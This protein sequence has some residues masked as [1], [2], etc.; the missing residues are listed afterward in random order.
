MENRSQRNPNRTE[1]WTSRLNRVAGELNIFLMVMAIG[2]AIL[3]FTCFFAFKVRDAL[4][5]P[6][7]VAAE[8]ALISKPAIAAGQPIAAVTPTKPGAVVTGW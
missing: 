6:A 5:S 3:D 1:R 2:L 7:R 8:P 4:P